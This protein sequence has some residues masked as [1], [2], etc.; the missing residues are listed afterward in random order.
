MKNSLMLTFLLVFLS[1]GLQGCNSSSEDSKAENSDVAPSGLSYDPSVF[2]LEKNTPLDVVN[3]SIRGTNL[4]FSISPALPLGITLNR[5]LGYLSGIPR[6]VAQDRVY[7]IKAE[8]SKGAVSTQVTLKVNDKILPSVSYAQSRY[9][10]IVGNSVGVLNPTVVGATF[11]SFTISPALPSGMNFNSNTGQITGTPTTVLANSYHLINAYIS[12]SLFVSTAISFEINDIPPTSLAYSTPNMVLQKG[13]VFN[14]VLPSSLGGAVVSFSINPALPAGLTLNTVTGRISGTPLTVLDTSLFV[15]TAM[16]TGGSTNTTVSLLIRDL[17]PVALSYGQPSFTWTKTVNVPQITPTVQGGAVLTYSITPSL[18][19]GLNFNIVNGAISGVPTVVTAARQHIITATNSG[20]T[21]TT[22]LTI[23]IRDL[24]PQNLSYPIVSEIYVKNTAITSISPTVQGGIV[25]SYTVNPALPQGLILESTSGI[26]SGTPGIVSNSSSYTVSANNS[27]GS[28]TY[29]FFITV[30]DE[31]PQNLSYPQLELVLEKGTPMPAISPSNDAGAIRTYAVTPILPTGIQIGPTTGIIAGTP[32]IVAE[33]SRYTITGTNPTGTTSRDLY[34]TVNDK[35]PTSLGYG[36][37]TYTFERGIPIA[38]LIPSNL[39]GNI[40]VYTVDP[41][42]PAGLTLNTT[43]GI[44]SGTPTVFQPTS[45]SYTITG[46]NTGG[47]TQTIININTNDFPPDRLSYSINGT[48]FLNKNIAIALPGFLPTY[49]GGQITSFEF[50]S[51]YPVP[52][53]LQINPTTGAITGTPSVKNTTAQL[54]RIIGRNS[55]GITSSDLNIRVYD[56]PPTLNL[57]NTDY[58]YTRLSAIAPI[59]PVATGGVVTSYVLSTDEGELNPPLP[60]GLTFNSSNGR[61]TGTPSVEFA[62]RLYVISGLNEGGESAVSFTLKVNRIIPSAINYGSNNIEILRDLHDYSTGPTTY[63]PVS[64]TPT[65]AG[66]PVVSWAISPSLPQGLSFNTTNGQITG[67]PLI[68]TAVV[69][70]TITA[71]NSGGTATHILNFKVR[72]LPPTNLVYEQAVWT[73]ETQDD[74]R[75]TGPN[76]MGGKPTYYSISPALP[77]GLFF[78]TAIGEITKIGNVMGGTYDFVVTAGNAEGTTTTNL[79]LLLTDS[80]PTGLLYSSPDG[81]AESFIYFTLGESSRSYSPVNGGGFITSYST[82]TIGTLS[83]GPTYATDNSDVVFTDIGALPA[84]I[85]VNPTTGIISGSVSSATNYQYRFDVKGTNAADSILSTIIMIFNRKPLAVTTPTVVTTIQTN[86][87]LSAAGSSDPDFDSR[88]IYYPEANLNRLG[89]RIE[90]YSWTVTSKPVGSNVINTSIN[91]SSSSVANF[92]PDKIGTYVFSV[93]ANDGVSNSNPAT[94]TVTVNDVPP[95]NLTY[96]ADNYGFD[97]FAYNIGQ[98]VS[99]SPTANGGEI[100]S[101]SITPS[102]PPGLSFST[103]TGA[104]TGAPTSSFTKRV[105]TIQGCNTGGCT[106]SNLTLWINAVPVASIT[107]VDRFNYPGTISLSGSGSTDPDR[108][109]AEALPYS[110]AS[111]NFTYQWTLKTKP[112]GSVLT[113]SSFSNPTGVSTNIVPDRKGTYVFE[114]VV[115][116]GLISSAIASKTIKVATAPSS[117]SYGSSVFGSNVF[118]YTINKENLNLIPSAAGDPVTSYSISPALPSGLSFST[119]TGA[120]TGIATAASAPTNY[121]IMATNDGGDATV[122]LRLWINQYPVAVTGANQ[123]GIVVGNSA[124]LDAAASYDVD[125]SF[126]GIA[127]FTAVVPTYTWELIGVPPTSSRTTTNITGRTTKVGTFSADV[128]GRYVFKFNY[129]DYFVSNQTLATTMITT[130]LNRQYVKPIADAGNNIQEYA[131]TGPHTISASSSSIRTGGPMTFNW[132]LISEPVGSTLE[133]LDPSLEDQDL[134][135]MFTGVYIFKLTVSDGINSA[136]DTISVI[137]GSDSTS[138]GGTIS[139]PQIWTAEDSP[140]VLTSNISLTA[141]ASITV[142]PGAVV[143]GDNFNINIANGSVN[144]SGNNLIPIFVKNLN[145]Q[146]NISGTAGVK[147]DYVYYEGGTLCA[148]NACN[149]QVLV[150]NSIFNNLNAIFKISNSTELVKVEKNIF[151]NSYGLE[152][153]SSSLGVQINNNFVYGTKGDGTARYFVKVLSDPLTLIKING[154]WFNNADNRIF[155]NQQAPTI[156]DAKKN[157]WVNG[158][159]ILFDLTQI[160]SVLVTPQNLNV[161]PYL[162]FPEA[163]VPDGFKFFN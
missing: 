108:A 80:P 133:I 14:S 30:K 144:F 52:A 35:A 82:E 26:I 116:D 109:V 37:T 157:Y 74:I 113:S 50:S 70:Y 151:A 79:Q 94:V 38:E 27:E 48:I 142:E 131:T 71:T 104:I 6:A 87:V 61:I 111:L 9:S 123:S 105:H 25:S 138:V 153:S 16:N 100:V 137:I 76:N 134:N 64:Y 21:T 93:T 146:K 73:Y 13:S 58:T 143:L 158:S 8:N 88:I 44:I 156:T 140:Y 56:E 147:L 45:Q 96:G 32:G 3:P 154:N 162:T 81:G 145:I 97:A 39:G 18:P 106:S 125:S 41:E 129:F 43:T 128:E 24:P 31:A 22:N 42:L 40:I 136:S 99:L 159:N 66:D 121:S 119:T 98:A 107:A 4:T 68:G 118:A 55:G 115:N 103:T 130:N 17:P 7:T 86:T 59:S 95:S 84:G 47:S 46:T 117:L 161:E 77:A 150:S 152:V 5:S 110:V 102:L 62:Q 112:A 114:L 29:S 78:N 127:P 57:S 122:T 23:T 2:V 72:D 69:P 12:D 49:N 149:G 90:S 139:T 148:N 92:T 85:S 1:L 160:K 11:S 54:V 83:P 63:T 135:F 34:I 28:S 155:I 51:T 101:Y 10:V 36:Q 53:G 124:T 75:V 65:T 89:A 15:I 20:G 120:I 141:S 60:T 33:R 126:G 132:E 91:N 19:T 67:I 163:V